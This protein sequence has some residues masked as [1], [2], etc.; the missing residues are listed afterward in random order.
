MVSEEKPD[1]VE[2]RKDLIFKIILAI[3]MFLVVSL[4][5]NRHWSDVQAGWRDGMED[6]AKAR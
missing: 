4:Y 6:G 1:P 5:V 2:N 3:V